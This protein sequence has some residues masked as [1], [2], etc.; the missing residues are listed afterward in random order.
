MPL[1]NYYVYIT[2]NPAKTVLYIGVTNNLERRILEHYNNR[3]NNKTFVGKYFCYKLI[4]YEYF[5]DIN[6]AYKE[7]RKL[8]ICAGRIKRY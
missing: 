4:Y 3:G 2:T 1:G 6:Q 8:K 5:P 7:K